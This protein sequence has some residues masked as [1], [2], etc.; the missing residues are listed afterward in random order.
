MNDFQKATP[1]AIPWQHGTWTEC[2]SVLRELTETYTYKH[3]LDNALK[4]LLGGPGQEHYVAIRRVNKINWLVEKI[5]FHGD[6]R[7]PEEFALQAD[8]K[9]ATAAAV[10][11]TLFPLA[12]A[13]EDMSLA[14]RPTARLQLEAAR[15]ILLED[16]ELIFDFDLMSESAWAFTTFFLARARAESR[17]DD[18]RV[19]LTSSQIV[20]DLRSR[21]PKRFIDMAHNLVHYLMTEGIVS[22]EE[23]LEHALV[24]GQ[25]YRQIGP[26]VDRGLVKVS[27]PEVLAA[28]AA[29]RPESFPAGTNFGPHEATVARLNAAFESTSHSSYL[30]YI[31]WY[32]ERERED[33]SEREQA[34]RLADS[35][36]AHYSMGLAH[37][38]VASLGVAVDV[39]AHA[40]SCLE[41][42]DPDMPRYAVAAATYE[43]DLLCAR[44]LPLD[45]FLP[46]IGS[47]L[48]ALRFGEGEEPLAGAAFFL[49]FRLELTAAAETEN[50]AAR[51][52]RLERV[53][54]LGRSAAAWFAA[55]GDAVSAGALAGLSDVLNLLRSGLQHGTQD[56]ERA[57]AELAEWLRRTEVEHWLTKPVLAMV[58]LL[59]D[60]APDPGDALVL[61][62]RQRYGADSPG[63][64]P[65][66]SV[67][68]MLL[69]ALTTV[70]L[71]RNEIGLGEAHERHSILTVVYEL[72][73][74]ATICGAWDAARE[75]SDAPLERAAELSREAAVQFALAGD[76]D[77]A[78]WLAQIAM[79]VRANNAV[80]RTIP[81][82]ELP[83]AS[84]STCAC[85]VAIV[86]WTA[87]VVLQ[88]L[89]GAGWELAGQFESKALLDLQ[90]RAA[91]ATGPGAVVALKKW[92]DD[93]GPVLNDVL[94]ETLVH[95]ESGGRPVLH[96]MTGCLTQYP[97]A[98]LATTRS[99]ITLPR[100]AVP[101][102]LA[103]EIV[104]ALE[105]PIASDS[106]C[107]FLA[108]AARQPGLA[109]VD[110]A[111]DLN[112]IRGLH[113]NVTVV[114]DPR[115][116]AAGEW[117][118]RDP[119]GIVHYAGHLV[120]AG[121]DL[122]ALV[123]ADGTELPLTQLRVTNL[124]GVQVV[125]LMCCYSSVSASVA[126][127]EQ[128]QHLAGAFLEAGASS[129]IATLW[130]AF[131]H[132]V[133]L[134]NEGFYEA[135]Q[136]GVDVLTGF[137]G[138]VDRVRRFTLGGAQPY[139]HPLFWA[140]FT[141]LA[142]A[143]SW[144]PVLGPGEARA[145]ALADYPDLLHTLRRFDESD[146][147]YEFKSSSDPEPDSHRT[148]NP[149]VL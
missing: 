66:S 64:E 90:W 54:S 135:A 1:A 138:A 51:A 144:V 141:L 37:G 58:N 143:G 120:P 20:A 80:A 108:G 38:S 72:L 116:A 59:V 142:G 146:D 124:H 7:E 130:P 91:D 61:A 47:S 109:A 14:D 15:T 41:V 4:A 42:S 23:R 89:V 132:P 98:L 115:E 101:G 24:V 129:V 106:R 86:G 68:Y 87:T 99:G 102:V 57:G 28:A 65:D 88:R 74:N 33:E 8:I 114:G 134:F 93:L 70:I 113:M 105:R 16:I 137:R 55:A 56:R 92:L 13:L 133:Q 63:S 122:T 39:Q 79:A 75:D 97:L 27:S 60:E 6:S 43:A 85:V 17:F 145:R 26:L 36:A 11:N 147:F 117:P 12:A 127:S 136:T 52:P 21:D 96:L 107:L 94:G 111:A 29:V 78:A 76:L 149:P 112:T 95:V 81:R 3:E 50:A 121:A 125:V 9:G 82:E 19:A 46:R 123:L 25:M 53:V 5:L 2:L 118:P 128:V 32:C 110:V 77:N 69:Q 139:A 45:T 22:E 119:P 67:D 49:L 131:D 140:G 35:A 148:E 62:L 104:P 10:C 34:R 30:K 18:F 126:S 103:D 100:V 84:L 73:R 31:T 83:T 48:T 40:L 71:R 44:R